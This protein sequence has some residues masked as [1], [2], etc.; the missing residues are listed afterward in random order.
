MI[1]VTYLALLALERAF[2]ARA[3]PEIRFW[4]LTGSL[5][6]VV[7]LGVNA[8]LPSLVPGDWLAR[9][10]LL[11]GG[12]LG[13]VGGVVV[14]YL[15]LS[16]VSY[17]VH[18]AEHRFGLAWRAL[19]QLHHSPPRVDLAGSAYTSP[20]E[21]VVFASL[22]MAVLVVVL[23][24]DPLAAALTGYVG[25]FYSMFQHWNVRTPR[26]L[27]YLIQRPESHCAHHERGVHAR[28]YG[29]LPLW[30]LVFGTFHN[31][32]GFQGE[33]GFEPRA[34]RRVG[35]MLLGVDVSAPSE[36][37]LAEVARHGAAERGSGEALSRIA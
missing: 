22:S 27:G 5:F 20:L 33:V 3:F 14:G 15:A 32:E 24:L 17:W 28:N 25:A 21:V 16:F 13:L 23:G 7:L 36:P 9:H 35:A 1:P 4:R 31:P 30:D 19:H 26:A 6:V 34:A 2:P 12:R 37:A 18:R 8:A 11:D 29:D 10:R